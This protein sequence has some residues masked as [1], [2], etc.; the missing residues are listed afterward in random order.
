MVVHDLNF[1]GIAVLPPKAH[2]K[3][4]IDPNAV[5]TGSIFRKLFELLLGGTRKSSSVLAEFTIVNL[6]C[7]TRRLY[8]HDVIMRLVTRYVKRN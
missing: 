2:A 4:I 7:V 8:R 6:R 1:V 3:L 5:L